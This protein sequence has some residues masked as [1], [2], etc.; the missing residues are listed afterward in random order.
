MATFLF[1]KFMSFF[2]KSILG[3][4]F[5]GNRHLLI[6]D[7]HG[8]HVTLE[9][10]KHAKKFGLD[11]ITLPS[12][13]SP[14]LQ[15]LNVF[16]FKPFKTTFRKVKDVAMSRSN[17]METNKITLARWVDQALEQSLTKQNIKFTT[18]CI[19]LLNPKAMDN[20]TKPL[21][22]YTTTNMSNAQVKKITQQRRKLRIIL[23]G[24][25]NLLS[26]NFSI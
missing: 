12:H 3:G 5:L 17:H 2:N 24:G 25:N 9:T 21:R 4:M 22:V 8:N 14:A 11:M 10:I 20:K 6:L 7:G 23:N 19:W 13:T 16:C 18:T 15:P 26:E 1:K